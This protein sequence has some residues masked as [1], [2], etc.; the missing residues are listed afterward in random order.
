MSIPNQILRK[1]SYTKEN[2]KKYQVAMHIFYKEILASFSNSTFSSEDQFLYEYH[3][4][5]TFQI[6]DSN[7]II[8]I[9]AKFFNCQIIL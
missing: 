5:D 9:T 7:E 2:K 1:L 4:K 6:L 8:D 3:F